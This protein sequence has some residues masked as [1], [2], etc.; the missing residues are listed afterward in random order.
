LRSV[1]V[2]VVGGGPAGI[3]AALASAE[4]GAETLLI[5]EN[6]EP[7]GQL[8]W[9][10]G[11]TIESTGELAIPAGPGHEIARKL[12]ERLNA[13][14]HLTVDTETVAWGMFEDNVLGISTESA[15]DEVQAGAIV[16]ATGSTDIAL[17]FPGWT[18]PG[19]MTARAAQIFL[20]IHRVLPGRKWGILG[21]TVEAE[22]LAL[23]LERAGVEV[24]TRCDDVDNLRASGTNRLA[25]IEVGED[26]YEVDTLAIALGRQ[27][28]AEL[29]FQAKADGAFV[30]ELGGYTVH[31][32]SDGQTSEP[33]VYIAGDAAGIASLDELVAE[34]RLAG[35]AA[36]GAPTAEISAAREKLWAVTSKRRS[37][38]VGRLRLNPT[39]A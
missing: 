1:D 4:S 16:L 6:V 34:G 35:L 27:P 2:V 25:H 14:A 24:V 29:A 38:A 30:F 26:V 8:R 9:R 15:A 39:N 5:D 11:M 7:G 3:C 17:P 37:D 32:D 20:H 21:N 28:D 18:L 33:G 12:T 23:D 10:I 31:R 36:A 13:T 22:E 19:V